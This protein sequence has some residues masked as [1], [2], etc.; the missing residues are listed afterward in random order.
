MSAVEL[1]KTKIA[2]VFCLRVRDIVPPPRAQVLE[3][4]APKLKT[5]G[6]GLAGYEGVGVLNVDG[7]PCVPTLPGL[8]VS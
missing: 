8:F 3:N 7:E 4:I 6:D 1:K 5:D 2:F